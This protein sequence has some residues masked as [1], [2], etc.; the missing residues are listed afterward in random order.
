MTL[1]GGIFA[2]CPM[3]LWLIGAISWGCNGP[4]R[5][6]RWSNSTALGQFSQVYG[7]LT[8]LSIP[9][10]RHNDYWMQIFR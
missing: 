8:G 1:I 9:E 5:P 10:L 4:K 6:P 2:P 7:G 3:P